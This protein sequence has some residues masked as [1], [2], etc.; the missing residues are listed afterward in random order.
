MYNTGGTNQFL[1]DNPYSSSMDSYFPSET[2][3][4]YFVDQLTVTDHIPF[5]SIHVESKMEEV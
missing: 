4:N 3:L 2:T 1:E 5:V